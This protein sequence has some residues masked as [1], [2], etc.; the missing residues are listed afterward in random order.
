MTAGGALVVGAAGGVGREVVRQLV[1]LGWS[2][3][4]TVMNDS[5]R[6]LLRQSVP[7]VGELA[8]VDLADADTISAALRPILP[9]GGALELV[10]VCAAISPYGPLETTPLSA[11]RRAFEINAIADVAVYQAVM[12]YLR[13]SKGRLL[14]I[15][16]MA[17]RVAF[18][19][20]GHYSASKFAL[21][22]LADVMRREAG[23]WGVEIIVVEPGGIQT[24]MVTDQQRSIAADS[25][26]LSN[27]VR[28]LYGDMYA[29][30]ERAIHGGYDSAARPT[31]VAEVIVAALTQPKPQTRYTVGPDAA[32]L[33]GAAR[34]M[35][36]REID[37]IAR[38]DTA[39]EKLAA[40]RS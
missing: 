28:E 18:P 36:D 34:T 5:Q 29:S 7:G 23:K 19:F 25:A 1:D 10:A 30:F 17:G 22:A 11:L 27:D 35:T 32:Y 37:G 2:V 38:L 21:E 33:C 39:N 3:C 12:P 26:A 24:P 20:V 13:K 31:E 40:P 16:S 9:S 4:G 15:S 8:I 14:M 6:R